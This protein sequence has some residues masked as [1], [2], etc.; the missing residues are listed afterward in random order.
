M[1]AVVSVL[2]GNPRAKNERSGDQA[3]AER[4]D[5]KQAATLHKS[6]FGAGRLKF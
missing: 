6:D 2:K 4:I 1:S 5:K 3:I